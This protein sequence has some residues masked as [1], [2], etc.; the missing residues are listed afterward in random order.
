MNN[1]KQKVVTGKVRLCY[2]NLFTRYA[3][4][5]TQ[6]PKY[7]VCVLIP[8]NDK[9]TIEKI[10][11]AIDSVKGQAVALWGGVVPKNIKT[12]LRNGNV[13]RPDQPEFADH[14]FINARSIRQ[15]GVFDINRNEILDST[16]VYSGCYARVSL[17]FYAYNKA[18]NKGIAVGINSVMKLDDG[19]LI[20]SPRR[21][22]DDFIDGGQNDPNDFLN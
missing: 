15:P 5:E 1:N 2:V 18:G 19:E 22:A 21:S 9:G 14:F 13:E 7:G 8:M 16:E 12:P 4:N 3:M 11:K 20:G 17:D 6:V 10:N